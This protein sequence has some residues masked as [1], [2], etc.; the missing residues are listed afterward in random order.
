MFDM[1]WTPWG[2]GDYK[3]GLWIMVLRRP[4]LADDP[5][6]WFC[7]T[8]RFCVKTHQWM[9]QSGSIGDEYFDA[10]VGWSRMPQPL[11]DVD[12]AFASSSDVFAALGVAPPTDLK[13]RVQAALRQPPLPVVPPTPAPNP[14]PAPA[15]PPQGTPGCYTCPPEA[16]Q[17][18]VR[19][20]TRSD[21]KVVR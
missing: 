8:M 1:T 11:A 12:G 3:S 20:L 14:N 19:R 6:S 18:T 16:Y 10:V 13:A 9:S 2:C 4:H 17:P 5:T 21:L 15:P 7:T